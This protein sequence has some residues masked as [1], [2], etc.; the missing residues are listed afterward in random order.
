MG[1]APANLAE[2]L[3]AVTVRQAHVQQKQ[4][5][6]VLFELRETQF[7]GFGARHAVAFTGE[8]HLEPF[9]DFRW[10]VNNQDGTL[11]DGP[12]SEPPGIQR[13]MKFLCREWSGHRSSRN[14][15]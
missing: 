8:Q 10:S 12:L 7:A 2:Q 13:G 3:K 14:V 11:R 4:I 5:V 6:R 1:V 15:P 9:T